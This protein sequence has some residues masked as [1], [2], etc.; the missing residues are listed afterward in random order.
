MNTIREKMDE[1]AQ[2][3]QE[4][5]AI[6]KDALEWVEAGALIPTKG[7]Y[8]RPTNKV[9]VADSYK[10]LRDVN[11]G[12]C[13]V[14]SRGA[15]FLAKAVRYN[16]VLANTLVPFEVDIQRNSET[17][18]RVALL[19]HFEQDQLTLIEEYYEGWSYG[20]D[21]YTW[22]C[23][24]PNHSQRMRLIL[25]NIIDNNGTFVPEKLPRT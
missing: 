13:K 21:P 15:L 4:R 24:F 12:K 16:N 20:A 18:N 3:A 6:A 14:C 22:Y 5:I 1:A 19:D 11:L 25:K 23:L 2:K 17:V 8:V 10:Q 7:T 9:D